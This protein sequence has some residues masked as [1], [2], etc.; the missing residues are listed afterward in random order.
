M[1]IPSISVYG[2]R[3]IGGIINAEVLYKEIPIKD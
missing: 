3:V 1:E 2:N